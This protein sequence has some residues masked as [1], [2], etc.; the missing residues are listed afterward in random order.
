MNG[1]KL[2]FMP[3]EPSNAPEKLR[4]RNTEKS[5]IGCAA[6]ISTIRNSAKLTAVAA[7]TLR[8]EALPKPVSA[9]CVTK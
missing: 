6:R 5:N 9:P 4:T 3:T 2:K 1:Q 7:I 8:A